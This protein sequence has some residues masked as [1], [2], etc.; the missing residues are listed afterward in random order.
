MDVDVIDAFI[1][2]T[3]NETLVHKLEQKSPRTSMELLDIVTSH[4]S[5]EDE[6]GA[7]FDCRKRKVGHDKES[8][9]GVG[10]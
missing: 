9:E 5:G 2:G 4:A 7:I 3:T 1:S 6:V 8:D 10:N